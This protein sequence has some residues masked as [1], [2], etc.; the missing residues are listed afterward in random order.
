[1]IVQNELRA[2]SVTGLDIAEADSETSNVD[3]AI[4]ALGRLHPQ[5]DHWRVGCGERSDRRQLGNAAV[6]VVAGATSSSA[7][8]DVTISG[9]CAAASSGTVQTSGGAAA[10]QPAA[11][12]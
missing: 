5:S 11:A 8:Q 10:A 9:G 4:D 1:M 7:G 3:L 6:S 2:E 12:P